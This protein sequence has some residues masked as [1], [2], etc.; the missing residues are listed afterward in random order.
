MNDMPRELGLPKYFD[1]NK[2]EV[3]TVL[4]LKGKYMG[5]TPSPKYGN[6]QRKF[7]QFGDDREV[8]LNGGQLNWREENG[9]LEV[10]GVYDVVYKG[11]EALK[12]GKFAGKDSHQFGIAVYED[13][14]L[15][16][17]DV[18]DDVTVVAGSTSSEAEAPL[19]D[20]E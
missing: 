14:E 15:S 11:T 9:Y 8:V 16:S 7:V 10:G 17:K 12:K 5:H 19:N 20:L 1:L 4:V 3:G 6:P 13:D 2:T 18:D